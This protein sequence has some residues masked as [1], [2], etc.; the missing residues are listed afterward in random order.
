MSNIT[1]KQVPESLHTAIKKEAE[2]NGRSLNKEILYR[3][4]QTLNMSGVP[5]EEILAQAQRVREN[6]GVYLTQADLDT[7]KHEGRA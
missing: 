5:S 4:E 1:L 2:R 6:L 7:F 3:L